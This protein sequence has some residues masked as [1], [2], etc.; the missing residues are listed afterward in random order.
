[1]LYHSLKHQQTSSVT[2]T[3]NVIANTC[4]LVRGGMIL[5]KIQLDNLANTNKLLLY[6]S[7]FLP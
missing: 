1:M 7:I 5:V 3:S 4:F 6:K 2:I